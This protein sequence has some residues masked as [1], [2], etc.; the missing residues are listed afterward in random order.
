MHNVQGQGRYAALSRSVP[1]TAGLGSIATL[2]RD[3]IIK[4]SE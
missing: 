3:V 1:C 4:I 2:E